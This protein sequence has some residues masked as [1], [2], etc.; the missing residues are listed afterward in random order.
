MGL[1]SDLR[2]YL[3]TSSKIS[4][5]GFD[6]FK[7][8]SVE[9][10]KTGLSLEERAL[11]DG[12][13][14]LPDKGDSNLSAAELAIE[15]AIEDVKTDYLNQYDS[16]Q[17]AY[18][19][20][21][22][23]YVSNWTID[24]VKN[25]ER[26]LV[27]EVIEGAKLA[28]D[29]RFESERRM[30][31]IS[32]EIVM[33]RRFH[34]LTQR[35][36]DVKSIGRFV[37]A[38]VML[39]AVEFAVSIFLLRETG[40]LQAVIMWALVY[41]TCNSAIPYY[42]GITT[43]RWCYLKNNSLK[44]NA[45]FIAMAAAL[46]L[47]IALN[48]FVGHYRAAGLKLKDLMLNGSSGEDL[49]A[50]Y[51]K[52]TQI[53]SEAVDSF[54]ASPFAIDDGLAYII[55]VAGFIVFA[56]TMREGVVRLDH[57]P[58]YGEL[59][60]RFLDARDTYD[61]EIQN[62]MDDL[63]AQRE[64]GI[65]KVNILKDMMKVSL[66]SVPTIMGASSS[67]KIRA[68]DALNKLEGKYRELVQFYR[69]TNKKAREGVAVPKYFGHFPSLEKAKLELPEFERLDEETK[70]R[71]MERVES[72]ADKLHEEFEK[73]IGELRSVDQILDESGYPFAVE[74]SNGQV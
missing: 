24:K 18:R 1:L 15:N 31:A 35:T 30:Q 54:L 66:T 3:N 6:I 16:N 71:L 45:G 22:A 61:E 23:V 62:L 44:R 41:S 27:S 73:I 19:D 56:A 72:F 51:Q 36:P 7:P 46:C 49:L 28:V 5:E 48:F 29:A 43:V 11:T 70:E 67:L 14:G 74:I 64:E 12:A 21:I 10:Y 57:Y 52:T 8:I 53:M 34:G 47:G 40:D 25:E 50:A 13:A 9:R 33:F 4:D 42:F 39:F 65:S 26:A 55:T 63:Q 59:L 37:F 69:E 60:K 17:R 68:E 58:G 38:M 2:D 32:N 20:R